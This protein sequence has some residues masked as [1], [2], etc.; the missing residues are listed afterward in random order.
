V[1]CRRRAGRRRSIEG[2][3]DF[4]GKAADAVKLHREADPY[5]AKKPMTESLVW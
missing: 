5:C 4:T 2:T 1:P 3:V